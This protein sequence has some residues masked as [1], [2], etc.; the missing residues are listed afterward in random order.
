MSKIINEGIQFG[1]S[2]GAIYN[3]IHEKYASTMTYID[4]ITPI[5]I[6]VANEEI[7]TVQKKRKCKA[8]NW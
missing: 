2:S 1:I 4:E 6:K 8:K 5:N 3:M 7:I